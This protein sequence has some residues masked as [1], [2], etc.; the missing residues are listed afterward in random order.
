[1]LGKKLYKP[2]KVQSAQ[3]CETIWLA[4][5]YGTKHFVFHNADVFVVFASKIQMQPLFHCYF[6]HT[7][8]LVASGVEITAIVI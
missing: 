5:L 8:E 2:L 6:Y 4:L 3:I 1:M 7:V